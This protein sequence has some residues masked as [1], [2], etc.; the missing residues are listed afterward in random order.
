MQASGARAILL[1]SAAML[2]FLLLSCT[3]ASVPQKADDSSTYVPAGSA[4]D[5][6]LLLPPPPAADSAAFALDEAIHDQAV[7]LR[8]TP[9]WELARSDADLKAPHAMSTFDC[10]LGIAV[11]QRDT[12]RLY[13]IIHRTLTDSGRATTSAKKLYQRIR[14]FAFHN[15]TSC[16]PEDE[17][18]LRGNGS[19]PSGHTAFGWATALLL[20]EVMPERTNEI[21]A[22]GRAYGESRLV[23]NVHWQSDVVEGIF[24][25]SAAVARMHAEP[26]LAEDIAIAR[27]EVAAARAKGL[28]PSRDCAAEAAAL[29]QKIPG[30]L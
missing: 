14:P 12:P 25:G 1:T 13:R 23:C 24:I 4:P 9:R 29:S 17:Q 15:E 8:D 2:T 7:Q 21:L 19:Y 22:R 18:T 20:T 10:A 26:Q 3:T 27:K 6:A 5:S 16:T 11:T 28:L 30:V